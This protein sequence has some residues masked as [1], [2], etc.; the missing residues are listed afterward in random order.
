M[1]IKCPG[2][3]ERVIWVDSWPVGGG[4]LKA[5]CSAVLLQVLTDWDCLSWTPMAPSVFGENGVIRKRRSERGDEGGGKWL[6]S[7]SLLITQW[8][9]DWI[10][11]DNRPFL[12]AQICSQPP[13]FWACHLSSPCTLALFYQSVCPFIPPLFHHFNRSSICPLISPYPSIYPSVH[14]TIHL[15][16]IHLFPSVYPSIHQSM[17]LF[18]KSSIYSFIHL[19]H[20]SFLPSIHI[21][22]HQIINPSTH[23]PT[24][25]FLFPPRSWTWIKAVMPAN[26]LL[27][28]FNLHYKYRQCFHFP[29]LPRSIP[30]WLLL[31]SALGAKKTQEKHKKKP[32]YKLYIYG[33]LAFII[34]IIR[35]KYIPNKRLFKTLCFDWALNI[36]FM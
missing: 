9:V 6:V 12:H 33:I 2:F 8:P 4:T 28:H 25:L 7:N 14:L 32:A 11:E 31:C 26:A 36:H 1:V 13:S 15:S 16:V 3:G 30:H 34:S 18:I 17:H 5:F 22:I 27:R 20:P 29:L 24:I 23:P 35:E 21:S 19:S 10:S